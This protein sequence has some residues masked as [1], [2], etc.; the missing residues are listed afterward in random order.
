M[1]ARV[2]HRKPVGRSENS[3][4]QRH[5]AGSR[6]L[7]DGEQ[8]IVAEIPDAQ[9]GDNTDSSHIAHHALQKQILSGRRAVPERSIQRNTSGKTLWHSAADIAL[10]I[11]ATVIHLLKTPITLLASIAIVILILA[12]IGRQVRSQLCSIPGSSYLISSCLIPDPPTGI[13][14]LKRLV[15][16]HEELDRIQ[17][18]AAGGISLPLLIKRGEAAIR[19]VSKRVELSDLPS[20][21]VPMERAFEILH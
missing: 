8:L 9:V 12:L 16:V 21:P 17:E 1:E 4:G 11:L 6:G 18:L 20:R 5:G 3:T 19:E 10:D 15:N 2:W 13:Q 7:G 14:E